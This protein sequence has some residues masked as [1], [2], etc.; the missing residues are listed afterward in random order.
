MNDEELH[1]AL[2]SLAGEPP[3]ADTTARAAVSRRV[4]SARRRIGAVTTAAV[5]VAAVGGVGIA[6]SAASDGSGSDPGVVAGRAPRCQS[7]PPAVPRARVPAA[8]RAWASGGAVVGEGSLWTTRRGL[9][10][11]TGSRD[12]N[13]TRIKFGWLVLPAATSVAPTLTARQ[14]NGPGRATGEAGE[15]FDQHGRWFASTIEITGPGRCWE[16][17][18]RR[19]SDTIVVRRPAR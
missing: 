8:V 15:A 4:R 5:V 6:Q 11:G 16:I 2:S 17:T 13:V 10:G 9:R 3:V 12:G 18:A 14:V 1:D 19:G 7:I